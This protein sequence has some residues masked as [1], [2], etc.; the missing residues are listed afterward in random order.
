MIQK[1][2]VWIMAL[3]LTLGLAGCAAPGTGNPE[4]IAGPV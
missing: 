2:G 4:G 3:I 1:A